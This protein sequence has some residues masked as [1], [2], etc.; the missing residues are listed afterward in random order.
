MSLLGEQPL[1]EGDADALRQRAG[2]EERRADEDVS[3][4]FDPPQKV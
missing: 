3:V 2:V 1:T 4:E